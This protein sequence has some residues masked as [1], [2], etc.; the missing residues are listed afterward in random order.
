MAS[1]KNAVI[2]VRRIS[3]EQWISDD[4]ALDIWTSD[5]LRNSFNESLDELQAK[6]EAAWQSAD[7]S[8]L[9]LSLSTIFP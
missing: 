8:I 7:R 4:V 9:S 2:V 3:R 6:L 5:L 1:L